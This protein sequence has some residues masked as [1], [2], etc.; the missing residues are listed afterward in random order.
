[1]F[2]AV[3]NTHVFVKPLGALLRLGLDSGIF[4]SI[5]FIVLG[6]PI[7]DVHIKNNNYNCD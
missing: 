2:V 5:Y 3:D 7:L 6:F 4:V 1:M